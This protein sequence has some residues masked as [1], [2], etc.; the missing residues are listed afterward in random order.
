MIIHDGC[1][2]NSSILQAHTLAPPARGSLV[3]GGPAYEMASLCASILVG[4]EV[5]EHVQSGHPAGMPQL[6]Q[7]HDFNIPQPRTSTTT[8][9]ACTAPTAAVLGQCD[10]HGADEQLVNLVVNTFRQGTGY[11][12]YVNTQTFSN[13]LVKLSKLAA[14]C[15]SKEER[16]L[17]LQSPIHIFGDIHGN[18][19]DLHFFSDNLWKFGAD[20]T[21]SKF[22]FL[23]D[24]VD[25]GQQSLEV[26]AYLFALKL[27]WPDKFFL[28]RGNHELRSMNGQRWP[29]SF[30][31]QCRRRFGE[32]IGMKVWEEINCAFDCMPLAAVVDESIFC[33]HGGVPRPTRA[34]RQSLVEAAGAQLPAPVKRRLDAPAALEGSVLTSRARSSLGRDRRLD[35][36]RAAPCPLRFPMLLE[37]LH[38][39]RTAAKPR[40]R[41]G[42]KRLVGVMA[43]DVLQ[44]DEL[45]DGL[46]RYN[47][48]HDILWADLA[49]DATE[50]GL[51]RYGFAPARRGT[52]R[53]QY[54]NRAIEEFLD[55]NGLKLIVR[56][57]QAISTGVRVS[58]SAK[59]FTVFSTSKD[60]G[61]G[62][63]ATC[64][65]LLVKQGKLIPIT[66][67]IHHARRT[68]P[69]PSTATVPLGTTVPAEACGGMSSV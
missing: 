63:K 28:I 40:V 42:T 31:G 53:V 37:G 17:S 66:R 8:D 12:R 32:A 67:A 44:D 30:K 50:S 19:K 23:G 29:T 9:C 21:D 24:Y 68:P 51:N 58:K 36:L 18:L 65:C 60:H 62:P 41:R 33:C 34:L 61:K 48:I 52:A 35:I 46:L 27:R 15:M 13:H 26:V 1:A 38:R 45:Y 4:N 43:G 5:K 64:G 11:E 39:R 56:A 25:R 49:T 7:K 59:V 3:F 22:L 69:A 16:L 57:H 2:N 54:G 10:G 47:V 14:Q 55:R 20:V 6:P